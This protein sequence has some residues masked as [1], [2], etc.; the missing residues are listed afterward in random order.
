MQIFAANFDSLILFRKTCSHG[1]IILASR[2]LAQQILS[3]FVSGL[4]FSLKFLTLL[5]FSKEEILFQVWSLE[6]QSNVVIRTADTDCLFIGLGCCEKL[7]PFLKI[8]LEV[9]CKVKII[10]DLLVLILYTLIYAKISARVFP[11]ITG[12]RYLTTQH[13]LVN[14]ERFS[15]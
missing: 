12:L 4:Y 8:W 10:C 11:L 13:S 1:D 3:P 14:K 9:G 5:E 15:S 2:F 6:N 7:D